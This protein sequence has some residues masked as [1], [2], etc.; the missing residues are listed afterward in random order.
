MIEIKHKGPVMVVPAGELESITMGGKW[1]IL[2]S[3][4]AQVREYV[5]QRWNYDKNCNDPGHEEMTQQQM[6]V[7][8]QS[9][10]D[11]LVEAREETRNAR[12]LLSEAE[13]REM[14]A[15]KDLEEARGE[16]ARLKDRVERVVKEREVAETARDTHRTMMQRGEEALADLRSKYKKLRAEVGEARARE[17]LG[18]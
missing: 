5:P 18:E 3:Y 15:A 6:F 16:V 17:L 4:Q 7:V 8:G 9:I 14:G 11:A 12:C 10:E 13:Q 2:A 1:H